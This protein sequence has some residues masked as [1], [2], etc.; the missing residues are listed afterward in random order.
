MDKMD[1]CQA[2]RKTVYRCRELD[3]CTVILIKENPLVI[4]LWL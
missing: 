4:S 3:E 2:T 1:L